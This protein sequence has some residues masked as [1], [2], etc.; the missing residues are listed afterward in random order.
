M[1]SPSGGTAQ[2]DG[3]AAGAWGERPAGGRA[4]TVTGRCPRSGPE[5]LA[6]VPAPP[7]QRPGGATADSWSLRSYL[8]LGALPGA[9]PCARLH[10]RQVLW[11]WGFH[12]I[13]DTAELL[14]SELATNALYASRAMK[15]APPIRLWLLSDKA[16]VVVSV[17]DGNRRPP[18]LTTPG[19]E[20]ESG[21]GLVLVNALSDR[22]DWYAP[23]SLGGKV[24][25]SMIALGTPPRARHHPGETG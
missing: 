13:G 21:R 18:V 11:E 16:R 25:W 20:A 22:W 12:M 24:V 8:E 10:V 15:H 1:R 14:V 3:G 6:P 5:S 9:V 2:A 4:G 17:W 23:E 7:P 19:D